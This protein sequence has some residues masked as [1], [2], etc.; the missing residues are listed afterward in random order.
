PTPPGVGAPAAPGVGV[1]SAPGV[2]APAPPG[3]VEA[4]N[5]TTIAALLNPRRP[6]SL[7]NLVPRCELIMRPRSSRDD[8]MLAFA[9]H[10]I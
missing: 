8:Q 4:S 10:S 3:V 6:N 7:T 2:G 5:T 1:P 9:D